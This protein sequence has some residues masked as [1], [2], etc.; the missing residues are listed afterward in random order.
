MKNFFYNI[1]L[2]NKEFNLKVYVFML[3]LSDI[4]HRLNVKELGFVIN[5]FKKEIDPLEEIKIYKKKKY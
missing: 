3:Y 4:V 2:D 1:Q 5:L